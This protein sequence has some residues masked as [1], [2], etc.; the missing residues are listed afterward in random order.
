[1]A[2]TRIPSAAWSI[3]SARVKAITAPLEA[4]YAARLRSPT[5]PATD[6]TFTIV[7]PPLLA[8]AGIACLQQR[9][10]P[11]TLT[12][13]TRSHV[14]SDVSGVLVVEPMPATLTSTSRR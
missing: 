2:L 14:S 13:K 5:R 9:N 6:E 10:V 8:S 7:P 12:A 1:T 4:Q 11:V 3:A